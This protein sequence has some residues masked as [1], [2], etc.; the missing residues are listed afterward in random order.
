MKWRT[1]KT[2]CRISETSSLFY[3][4]INKIDKLENKKEIA[5]FLDAFCLSKFKQKDINHLN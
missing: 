4:K 2:I 5:K 1:S 3:E